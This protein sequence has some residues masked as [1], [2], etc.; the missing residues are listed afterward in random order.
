MNIKDVETKTGLTKRMIRHYEEFG[1]LS[2][3][4]AQ[5]VRTYALLGRT[6]SICRSSASAQAFK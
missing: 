3:Q 6:A 4:R 1:L 5:K 2:P